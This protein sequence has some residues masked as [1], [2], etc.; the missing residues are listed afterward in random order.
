MVSNYSLSTNS[1][2]QTEIELERLYEKL[3]K[4][5]VH[6]YRR[7]LRHVKTLR[8]HM[9]MIHREIDNAFHNAYQSYETDTHNLSRTI[10]EFQ[11]DIAKLRNACCEGCSDDK[12][13]NRSFYFGSDEL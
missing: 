5:E 9:T 13:L 11:E 3:L 1:E 12:K 4:L 6:L 8:Q 10:R 2:S 7:R